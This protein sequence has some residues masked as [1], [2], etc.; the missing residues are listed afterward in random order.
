MLVVSHC[1]KYECSYM[2][3]AV[4]SFLL[5]SYTITQ[6]DMNIHVWIAHY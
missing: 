5:T 4:A 2:I 6:K 3:C 1:T